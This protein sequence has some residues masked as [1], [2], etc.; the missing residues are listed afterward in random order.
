MVI[1]YTDLDAAEVIYNVK[2]NLEKE[3][4]CFFKI[5]YYLYF[6]MKKIGPKKSK[7]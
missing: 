4:P 7:I 6:K 2:V 5:T 1:F 3:L